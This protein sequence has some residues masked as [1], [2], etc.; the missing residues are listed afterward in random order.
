METSAP[1][2]INKCPLDFGNTHCKFLFHVVIVM[3]V[4]VGEENE[5]QNFIK[6]LKI[7]QCPPHSTR[8]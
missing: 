3:S 1:A 7:P 5:R 2:D 6:R 8:A 4:N